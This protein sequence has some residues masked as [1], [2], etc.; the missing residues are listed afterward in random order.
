[1]APCVQVEMTGL[2]AKTSLYGAAVP[3]KAPCQTYLLLNFI[4]IFPA[5]LPST[6][7]NTTP[8]NLRQPKTPPYMKCTLYITTTEPKTWAK[9]IGE[10]FDTCR[11]P[12]LTAPY[13]RACSIK[14]AERPD[15]RQGRVFGALN[16]SRI[17]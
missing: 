12:G 11:T 13:A 7:A 4:N 16:T 1:M 9:G 5:G 14:L 6:C 2:F 3:K 10:L 17:L 8:R 15:C